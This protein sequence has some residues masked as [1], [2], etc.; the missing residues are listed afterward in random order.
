[1]KTVPRKELAGLGS[2][3]HGGQGWRYSGVED[4]SQN[5]NPAGMPPGLP[6]A[7]AAATS[8]FTH[9]PDA[10]CTELRR[11]IAEHHGLSADNITMGAGSSEIIRDF[12][13]SFIDPG[14]RVLVPR[15]SFAEY[16]QQILLAG[17][18]IDYMDLGPEKNFHI[19]IE[20][21][22]R[23][24]GSAEYKAMYVCNPN[25]PTG[26]VE[27]RRTLE[28]IARE[29]EKHGTLLF[30][31]ETLLELVDSEPEVSLIPRIADHPNVIIARSFTK[32][33]AV[34]GIR[35]GYGISNPGIIA[36]MQKTRLPWNIGT[37]EQ[38][39]AAFMTDNFGFVEKAARD[40]REEAP[41]LFGELK[42]AGLP[43]EKDTESFFHF[44]DLSPT[45]ISVADFI[46]EM[47]SRGFMVRDCASFGFPTY[48]RFCVKD[49]GRDSRFAKAVGE[50]LAKLKR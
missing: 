25:N 47:K 21:V 45:G 19:D 36:E 27:N 46:A 6:E 30:L 26:R 34:P 32:S 23:R 10:D 44:M 12:P 17:G 8:N 11:K 28:E 43:L 29:C 5:L 40:L 16:S 48:I 22:R 42:E 33:F 49:R 7:I 15:P 20:E 3:V 41:L 24:L 13:F 37:M 31:D 50:T 14:D 35:V 2:T 4:Y 18:I 38:A 9:Y 1:M 39:A